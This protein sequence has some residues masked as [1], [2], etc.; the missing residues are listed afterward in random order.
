VIIAILLATVLLLAGLV[1]R[2]RLRFLQLLFIPASVAGGAVGFLLIQAAQRSRIVAE[3]AAALAVTWRSWPALLIA[4]VFAGLLLERPSQRLSEAVRSAARAGAYAWIVVVGQ[5]VIGLAA[6]WLLIQPAMQV[7]AAFGQLLE[8]G[9]AGGHGTAGALGA[10]YSDL[11]DFPEGLDLAMF[12]ATVGVL[13]SVVS[14]IAFVNLA[15]RRGWTR[16]RHTDEDPVARLKPLLVPR[17]IAWARVRSGIAG[18]L[19][20]QVVILALAILA[21]IGLQR[22]FVA[23]GTALRADAALPYLDKV[24]L[25]VFTLLGGLAVRRAM[26]WLGA[27]DLIDGESIKRLVAIAMEFLI[28]AAIASLRVEALAAYFW[29]V[30]LLIVLGCVWTGFCLL[31]LARRLL[32]ASYWFELGIINYGMSTGTT[33]QGMLLLRMIDRDLESGAAEDYALAAPLSAPFIG[34]GVITFTLP[35]VLAKVGLPIVV[36]ASAAVL[37]GLVVLAWSLNRSTSGTRAGRGPRQG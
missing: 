37:A 11:L 9:F 16:T 31:V 35:L 5:I 26:A 14:G 28:V 17:S 29:P 27:G 22:L 4:V 3:P 24:P 32:P 6:T 15:V 13:Y 1:L 30:A 19:A 25:F 18:P 34:G 20:L 2:A 12:V 21:G 7:P 10:V 8:A 33:A 36:V 23:A